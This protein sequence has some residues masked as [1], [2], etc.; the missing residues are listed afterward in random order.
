MPSTQ[1]QNLYHIQTQKFEEIIKSFPPDA[2]SYRKTSNDH[3]AWWVWPTTKEGSNEKNYID[4]NTAVKDENDAVWLIQSH[5]KRTKC[6]DHWGRILDYIGDAIAISGIG[7][8]PGVD[9]GRI[10]FFYREWYMHMRTV[11]QS[12]NDDISFF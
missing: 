3:W 10:D 5:Q 2:K 9:H 11:D 1:A 12:V 8:L 4:V 6:L 7:I